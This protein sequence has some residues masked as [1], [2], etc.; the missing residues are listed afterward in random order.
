MPRNGTMQGF[1]YIQ[2]EGTTTV[3]GVRTR[4][5]VQGLD[6]ENLKRGKEYLIWFELADEKP[7]E[8]TVHLTFASL[9]PSEFGGF[10]LSGI[11]KALGIEF[12]DGD[13]EEKTQ[14]QPAAKQPT[15]KPRNPDEPPAIIGAA[16]RGD[17]EALRAQIQEGADVDLVWR[18]RYG[19][20]KTPLIAAIENGW[21]EVVEVLLEAKAD[22]NAPASLGSEIEQG[23]P[24]IKETHLSAVNVANA[25]GDVEIFLKLI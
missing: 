12:R 20:V 5:I 15:P 2:G 25:R 18:P 10:K 14:A 19:S 16:R 6:G 8:M 21:V 13:D 11:T 4:A 17:V 7:F 1:E 9:E 23:Y 3:N 22:P 24:E